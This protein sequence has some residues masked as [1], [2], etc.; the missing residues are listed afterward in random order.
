MGLRDRIRG[1]LGFNEPPDRL[2]LAFAIG[3]FIAFTPMVGLHT[4]IAFFLAWVFR[5]NKAVIFSGTL[6]CNP[7]TAI[8]IYGF[9]LWFG[10]KLMGKE[11]VMNIGWKNLNILSLWGEFKPLLLPFFLGTIISGTVAAI[12]SYFIFYYLIKRYRRIGGLT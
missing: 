4:V 10:A 2:A 3:A 11:I 5:W 7:Y 1:I 6:I 8:P 9:C 12:I